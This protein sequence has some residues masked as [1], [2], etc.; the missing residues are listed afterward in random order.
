MPGRRAT[1]TR[2]WMKTEM[3]TWAKMREN[4][5]ECVGE[6]AAKDWNENMGEDEED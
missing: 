6:E 3:N 1:A 5:D 4:V 2:M